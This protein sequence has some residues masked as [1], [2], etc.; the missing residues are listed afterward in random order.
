MRKLYRLG[1]SIFYNKKE[2][3]LFFLYLVSILY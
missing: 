3:V 1:T 2:N